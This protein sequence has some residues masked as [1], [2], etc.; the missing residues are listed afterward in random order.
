M[1]ASSACNVVPS[2][3]PLRGL[4][5][6]CPLGIIV[7]EMALPNRFSKKELRNARQATRAKRRARRK[8]HFANAC[9]GKIRHADQTGA[10][11]CLK[12]MNQ[13]DLSPYHC[14]HCGGWHVGHR[15]KKIQSRLD[16][17]FGA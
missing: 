16:Q 2:P 6:G 3:D 4:A 5:G 17:I 9:R 14:R 8:H 1:H 7:S 15:G 11:I 13:A 12:R 10:I